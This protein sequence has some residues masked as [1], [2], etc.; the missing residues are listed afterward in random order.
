MGELEEEEK[1]YRIS[2]R[3]SKGRRRND[4]KKSRTKPAGMYNVLGDGSE[5][6]VVELACI[7]VR[8]ALTTVISLLC[9]F[10]R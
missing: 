8:A 10:V 4:P 3:K 2:V 5:G 1:G 9:S 7:A 6:T